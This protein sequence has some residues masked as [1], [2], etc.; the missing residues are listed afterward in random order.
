[1]GH[2][3][4]TGSDPRRQAAGRLP[5]TELGHRTRPT[6]DAYHQHKAEHF[7]EPRLLRDVRFVLDLVGERY[8]A[9][10][11]GFYPVVNG[12]RPWGY[13]WAV[14]LPCSNCG[15]R[16]PLTGSLALRNSNAKKD[17][18]GQSYRIVADRA[19]GNFVTEVH[20]G[21]PAAQP[22]LVR[23]KGQRGKSGVCPLCQHAH[24]SDTLKRMMRDGHRD[25]AMLVVADLDLDVG[26]RYRTPV[27]TDLDAITGWPS[28]WGSKL[29]LV[30]V[31]PP[32]RPSRLTLDFQ[33]SSAPSTTATEAGVNY[34]THAKL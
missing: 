2:R 13:L 15:S 18:L 1:M 10:M 31:Y 22:T 3:L 5:T 20:D 7:T 26:K 11:G 8:E 19:S 23:A 6:F 21:S 27:D 34:V 24:P 28:P 12:K 30:W 25:D 17:D 32:C 4:L 14:T 16:F 29:R 9:E 33:D